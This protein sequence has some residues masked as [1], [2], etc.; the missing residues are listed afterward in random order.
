MAKLIWS[1]TDAPFPA[2]I[3]GGPNWTVT[4]SKEIEHY[5][6]ESGAQASINTGGGVDAIVFDGLASDYTVRL[7]GTNAVFTHTATNHSVS[8][9][10]GLEGD[11]VSFLHG[12]PML[13]Q[14]VRNPDQTI[15][16]KLGTQELTSTDSEITDGAPALTDQSVDGL[17]VNVNPAAATFDVW[18]DSYNFQDSMTIA[19]HVVI[20][21][22][23]AD[24]QITISGATDQA[25]FAANAFSSNAAGDVTIDYAQGGIASTIMLTGVAVGESVFDLASFNALPVGDLVFA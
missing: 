17:D 16:L 3:Y 20:N 7:D 12:D 8:L 2:Q 19:N 21:G 24:D 22:Y 18:T 9:K 14:I 10:M 5:A 4:G 15:S 23:G 1:E 11:H 13:L 25:D 6:V